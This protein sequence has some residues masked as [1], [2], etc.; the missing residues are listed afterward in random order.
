MKTI[1]LQHNKPNNNNSHNFSHFEKTCILLV[2]L[3]FLNQSVAL[4]KKLSSRYSVSLANLSRPA[5]G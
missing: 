2:Y 1:K 5:A 3:S 4:S